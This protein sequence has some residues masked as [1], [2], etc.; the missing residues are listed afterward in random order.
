MSWDSKPQRF[1]N[2]NGYGNNEMEFWNWFWTDMATNLKDC[3]NVI[4]E[5]WNEPGWN[6]D[7][8]EPIPAG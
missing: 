1:L 3:P 7:D 2:D 4:F 8:T 5:A 6:G